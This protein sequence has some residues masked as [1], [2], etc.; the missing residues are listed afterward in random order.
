MKKIISILSAVVLLM[1]VASS[2]AVSAEEQSLELSQSIRRPCRN[3]IYKS[4]YWQSG[5]CT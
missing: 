5:V 3:G 4:L 1:A 2:T